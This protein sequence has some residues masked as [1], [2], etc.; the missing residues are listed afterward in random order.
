[1]LVVFCSAVTDYATDTA[2]RSKCLFE[3][4]VSVPRGRAGTG[5]L[6]ALDHVA[7]PRISVYEEAERARLKLE[8][9][10]HLTV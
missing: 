1:M 4:A 8:P 5:A 2:K 10:P 7:K 9:S 6:K 3:L